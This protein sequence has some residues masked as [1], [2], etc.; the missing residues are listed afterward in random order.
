[1]VSRSHGI[2]ELRVNGK[3]ERYKVLQTLEFSSDRKRMSVIVKGKQGLMLLCKGADDVMLPLATSNSQDAHTAHLHTVLEEYAK[4][5]L[6]TLVFA[7]KTLDEATY[8]AW[9]A[10][11]EQA[12]LQLE[13]RKSRLEVV[14]AE[15]ERDLRLLAVTGIEDRLQAHVPETIATMRL[16]GVK[17]WM[18]TGDKYQTALE[19]SRSCALISPADRVF[20]I[21]GCSTAEVMQCMVHIGAT[22]DEMRDRDRELRLPPS[23]TPSVAS[24][25]SSPSP[26]SSSS[27]SG[28]ASSV[29]PPYSIIVEGSALSLI[30]THCAA[31][32]SEISLQAVSVV[33]C[34]VTPS[35][36][37]SV[38][39]LV[40]KAKKVVLAIGDGGN[41]VSMIQEADVGVGISGREGLQAAR[42]ADYSIA[43][44]S[45]LAR[46]CLV[47][48]RYAY[49]RTS[50]IAQYCFYKSLFLCLIQLTFAGHSGYSGASF[51]DSWSLM[52]YNMFY[53]SVPVMFYCLEQDVS[54]TTLLLNPGLYRTSRLGTRLTW[55]TVAS[56]WLMAF[57]HALVFWFFGI[58]A[59]SSSSSSHMGMGGQAFNPRNRLLGHDDQASA[60][61]IAYTGVVFLQTFVVVLYS[62]YITIYNALALIGAVVVYFIVNSILAIMPHQS[63]YHVFFS[64]LP[65][66]SYYLRVLLMV[67][68]AAVPMLALQYYQNRY[69]CPPEQA[70]RQ[71]ER[72]YDLIHLA[73]SKSHDTLADGLLDDMGELGAVRHNGFM[74]LEF[75]QAKSSVA[76]ASGSLNR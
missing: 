19:I 43:S 73:R 37:A 56:W 44:F 54:P 36:K 55:K 38:V 50:F 49:N 69:H 11:W 67:V 58:Y 21:R 1:L 17:V 18:L 29:L 32:F 20:T 64:I 22:L 52:T 42:A 12:N 28:D 16:A 6:R 62:T 59:S 33:C 24:P 48:G 14:Y 51:F 23:T 65:D 72:R 70:A 39:A 63:P 15:I 71:A 74:G 31:K 45:F 10:Q 26:S 76:V 75:D 61:L 46:L 7:Y 60:A 53:T 5:G 34:R 40:K 3:R 13:D 66:P 68:V 27:S 25:L 2:V 57:Y 47:H 30:L 41:D 9:A 8:R 4:R 35:Q